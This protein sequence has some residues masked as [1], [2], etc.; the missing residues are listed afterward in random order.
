[1]HKRIPDVKIKRQ[2]SDHYLKGICS[3]TSQYRIYIIEIKSPN[4]FYDRYL[5]QTNDL[6]IET[7]KVFTQY[8]KS[9]PHQNSHRANSNS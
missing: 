6:D 9:I 5:I 3:L 4:S 2:L 7:S 1:M 8:I